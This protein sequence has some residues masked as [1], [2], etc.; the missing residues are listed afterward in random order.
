MA[1]DKFSISMPEELVLALDEAAAEDGLTRSGVLREAASRYLASRESEALREERTRGVD[2]AL[3]A[4]DEIAAEWG[5]DD[6]PGVDYLRE[7]RGDRRVE[8]VFTNPG[9]TD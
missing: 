1:V 8:D 3:D 2:A 6:R 7:I 4:F 5:R 9:G